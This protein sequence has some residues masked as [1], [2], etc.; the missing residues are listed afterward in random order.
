MDVAYQPG[1]ILARSSSTFQRKRAGEVLEQEAEA[2]HYDRIGRCCAYLTFLGAADPACNGAFLIE[3]REP[4]GRGRG[5]YCKSISWR[6]SHVRPHHPPVWQ[7][8]PPAAL[9]QYSER[10]FNEP[11]KSIACRAITGACGN[12]L[13]TTKFSSSIRSLLCAVNDPSSAIGTHFDYVRPNLNS[14]CFIPDFYSAVP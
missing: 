11:A 10:K 14:G 8:L 12:C 5:I 1:S 9:A 13:C 3:C 4:I 7:H 6:R 2:L